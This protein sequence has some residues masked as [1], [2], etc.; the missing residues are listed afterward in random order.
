[1]YIKL[2]ET[3][4]ML[5]GKTALILGAS[6][7]IGACIA[8]AFVANG[9]RV[10]LAARGVEEMEAMAEKFR[11][12]GGEAHIIATDVTDPA[13]LKAAVDATVR[14]F[15][16][17]DIAVNNAGISQVRTDFHNLA[18][19]AFDATLN[20]NVRCLLMAMQL[21]IKAMLA[22]GGGSIVNIA[23]VTSVVGVPNM[24][25]Y[26]AS[27]HA[28]LGLTKSAALDYAQR[29]IRINAVAPGPTM[30]AQLKAGGAATPE[31]EEKMRLMIPMGRIGQPH[32]I[33]GA[34]TFLSSDAASFMTGVYLPV[35]GGFIVP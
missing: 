6:R 17:L 11:A 28:M 31:G 25:A 32:E 27:R 23:S 16:R 18:L 19:E 5:D 33:A 1:M 2:G 8:E 13:A 14:V 24:A 21:Q 20:I 12:A 29:N 26:V 4:R 10:M 22:Q 9:A 30:T 34:V 3:G 35:D 7:G 15:G